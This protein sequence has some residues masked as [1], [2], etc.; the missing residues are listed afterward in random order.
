M[1]VYVDSTPLEDE[2]GKDD[3]GAAERLPDRVRVRGTPGSVGVKVWFPIT[4]RR[5]KVWDSREEDGSVRSERSL[6][7]LDNFRGSVTRSGGLD[8][9]E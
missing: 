5:A 9:I 6:V 7:C 2:P 1:W 8:T 3:G 4:V